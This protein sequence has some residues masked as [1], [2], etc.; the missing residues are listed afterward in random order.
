MAVAAALAIGVFTSRADAEPHPQI[1]KILEIG[2]GESFRVLEPA[3]EQYEL[4]REAARRDPRAPYAMA[5]V[6]VKHG[7]HAEAARLLDETLALDPRHVA[8]REAKIWID[9]LLKRYPAA[10]AQIEELGGILP[11]EGLRGLADEAAV[12]ARYRESARFL[13]RLFGFLEG[14]AEKAANPD[15]V[16]ESKTRVL[17][18]LTPSQQEEFAAG[19]KAVLDRFGEFFARREQAKEDELAGQKKKQEEDTKRL[20]EERA[21]VA[22]NQQGLQK[23]AAQTREELEKFLSELAKQMAPLDREYSRL[24]AQGVAVRN[25]L[26]DY[27]RDIDRLLRLAELAKEPA[28]AARL[29]LEAERLDVLRDRLSVDYRLR[30]AEASRV[31]AAQ[32]AIL[33]QRDTAIAR[34]NAEA[35]RLGKEQFKLAQDEKRI[36]REED[37]AR[38]PPTGNTDRVH[39]LSQKATAFTTYEPFPLEQAKS[40]LLESLR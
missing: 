9:V 33:N 27:D 22:A 5:L 14:P 20:A 38:K 11:N 19:R 31:Q 15:R 17:L 39:V 23:Q 18:K 1:A 4:V 29:R 25:R 37:R 16:A 12:Q 32:A 26:V 30:Q 34:F 7:K 8:A 36:A 10:L 13:G 21:A 2:W 6:C 35:K 3:R 28:E 24:Y 40:R